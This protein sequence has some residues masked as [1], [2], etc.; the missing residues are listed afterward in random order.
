MNNNTKHGIWSNYEEEKEKRTEQTT[1]DNTLST[2]F[3]KMEE[4]KEK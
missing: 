1:Y 4:Q 2:K 3:E